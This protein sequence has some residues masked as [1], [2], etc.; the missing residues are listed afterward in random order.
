MLVGYIFGLRLAPRNA[1]II[2][3]DVDPAVAGRQLVGN[4]G[5]AG[6]V[7]HVHHGDLDI[8]ALCFQARAT[9][10]GKPAIA[11]RDHD[12]CPRLGQGFRAG[13]SYSL[14]GAGYDGRFSVE[15]EFFQIHFLFFLL[16]WL[17]VTAFVR[18]LMS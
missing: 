14:P 1:R 18:S 9:G 8:Q 6:G 5:H 17:R 12:L 15:P 11:I 13:K 2:D 3:E 4:L 16:A 10:L 7:R